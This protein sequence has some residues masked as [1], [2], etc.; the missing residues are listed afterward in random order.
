QIDNITIRQRFKRLNVLHAATAYFAEDGSTNLASYVLQ[1]ANGQTNEIPIVYGQN[2]ADWWFDPNDSPQGLSVP[3]DARVAWE[4]K[5][6]AVKAY[7][8]SLRIYQMSWDNPLPDIEVVSISLVSRMNLSAP[9]V[10]ALT[11]DR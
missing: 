9:F 6:E 7:E 2:I 10:I 4:G 11:L 8:K 1:Y 3:K 5:N